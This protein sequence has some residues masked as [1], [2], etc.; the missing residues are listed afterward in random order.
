MAEDAHSDAAGARGTC[1]RCPVCLL[2]DHG[3]DLRPEVRQHLRA[4]G[5]ELAMALLAALDSADAD[6]D[7]PPA[8]LR[9]VDLDEA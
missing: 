4:A 3:P 6:A 9:R 8:G 2:L 1:Q 5:R 7:E